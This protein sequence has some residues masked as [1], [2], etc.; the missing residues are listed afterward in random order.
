MFDSDGDGRCPREW[1]RARQHLVEDD[2]ETVHIRSWRELNSFT[3][4]WRHVARCA[5][6]RADLSQCWWVVVVNRFGCELGDAK[7][8]DLNKGRSILALNNKDVRGLQ[9]AMDNSGIVRRADS[10]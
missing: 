8:Q 2:T 10:G 4:L 3:L 7:V 1:G 6:H 9:I 5:N